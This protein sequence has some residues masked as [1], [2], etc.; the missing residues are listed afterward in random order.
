M[1]EI[2]QLD[3]I[4]YIERG[5]ENPSKGKGEKRE[6]GRRRGE[7]VQSAKGPTSSRGMEV[8]A[9]RKE[10]CRNGRGGSSCRGVM[11]RG[12]YAEY[13]GPGLLRVSWRGRGFNSPWR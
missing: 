6:D 10:A 8:E 7:A 1:G 3:Y 9:G 11:A 2:G 13:T 12:R 4:E 5:I